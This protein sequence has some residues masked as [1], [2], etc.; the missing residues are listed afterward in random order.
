MALSESLLVSGVTSSQP[1]LPY[2]QPTRSVRLRAP[3]VTAAVG[4]MIDPVTNLVRQSNPNIE[5]RAVS[6]DFLRTF[7]SSKVLGRDDL[8]RAATDAAISFLQGEIRNVQ[9]Q[10]KRVDQQSSGPVGALTRENSARMRAKKKLTEKLSLLKADLKKRR[11]RP[12][13]S[14]RDVH[15]LIIKPETDRLRCRYVELPGW[16]DKAC[17]GVPFIGD[18]SSFVSHSWD[19][20]WEELVAALC[21]HAEQQNGAY[22]YWVDIFAVIQHWHT[23]EEKV[24]QPGHMPTACTPS[25]IGCVAAAEDMPDWERMQAS[26]HSGGFG[27]VLSA[28]SHVLVLMEPWHTPRPPTRVWCLYEMYKCLELNGGT[29]EVVLSRLQQQAMQV[30]LSENFSKFESLI[31]GLDARDAEV[32]QPSDRV[33]I[34]GLIRSSEGSFG[35]LNAAIRAAL[36]SWLVDA[37]R[38][39]LHRVNPA[40]RPLRQAELAQE[41]E[42]HDYGRCGACLLRFVNRNPAAIVLLPALGWALLSATSFA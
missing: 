30:A 7:T 16:G 14:T 13:L 35:A 24:G 29:A 5:G 9:Q 32:T 37:G 23:P 8:A 11:K 41:A 28:C 21:E 34:F 42:R 18:A 17:G 4:I 27:R 36:F 26:S 15:K 25:C 2:S 12:F 40:S 31:M 1:L 39:L 19:S 33:N 22:Y 38:S 10:L 20:P 3:A 6:A